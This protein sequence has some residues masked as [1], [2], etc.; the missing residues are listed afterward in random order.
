MQ[1]S[2]ENKQIVHFIETTHDLNWMPKLDDFKRL[3][4]YFKMLHV[5]ARVTTYVD[6]AAIERIRRKR[7]PSLL[8]ALCDVYGTRIVKQRL[9]ELLN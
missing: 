1:F 3:S 8:S 9:A 2:A 4:R 7:R 5:L 6:T